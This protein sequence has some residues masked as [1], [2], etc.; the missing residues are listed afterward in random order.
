MFIRV[1]VGSARSWPTRPA[2]WNVEPL[3][4]S[5]RSSEHDVGLAALGEVVGDARAADA[6]ADDH[7]R[8]RGRAESGHPPSSGTAGPY[9]LSV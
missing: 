4:S 2:R 6:A 7:D 8:G 5:A 9:W 3:V 1:S